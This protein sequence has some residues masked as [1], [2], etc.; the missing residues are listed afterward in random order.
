M[1]WSFSAIGKP[2]NVAAALKKHGEA[3]TGQCKLEFDAALPHLVGLVEQNFS[4]DGSG[5]GEPIID[6][7]ASG[8]GISTGSKPGGTG[9]PNRQLQRDC[10]VKIGRSYRQLV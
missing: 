7:E 1:S 4:A 9:E 3:L 5:Y 2:A 6:I 10:T 8:S